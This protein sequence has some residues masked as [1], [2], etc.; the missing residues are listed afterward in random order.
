MTTTL[1][2]VDLGY[3]MY[4]LH[5]G[6]R[7]IGWVAGIGIGFRGFWSVEDAA[8]RAAT[9]HHALS[10]WLARQ[11]RTAAAPPAADA[12]R[13][14]RDEARAELTIGD[15]VVGWVVPMG[16]SRRGQPTEYAFE[17]RLPEVIDP[18]LTLSAA[19]A[20]QAALERRDGA[21]AVATLQG[22]RRGRRLTLAGD[23]RA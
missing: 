2:A 17:L 10:R 15:V 20:V 8:R 23:A 21:H 5:A 3:G 4:R 18:S 1:N 13:L 22:A 9:A 6:D 14:R 12:L 19:R 11:R 7:E 16:V